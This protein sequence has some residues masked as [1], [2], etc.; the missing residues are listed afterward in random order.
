MTHEELKNWFNDKYKLSIE[1]ST[2]SKIIK[3]FIINN[4]EKNLN[5]KKNRK[6]KFPHLESALFEWVLQ[7]ENVATITDGVLL[8]KAK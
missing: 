8:E 4:E 5:V 3:K 7:Y 2:V 1:R 6:P